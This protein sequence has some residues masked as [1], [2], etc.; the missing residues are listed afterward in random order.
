MSIVL[1]HKWSDETIIIESSN[2]DFYLQCFKHKILGKYDNLYLIEIQENEFRRDTSIYYSHIIRYRFLGYLLPNEDNI[3]SAYFLCTS[4]FQRIENLEECSMCETIFSEKEN[5]FFLN[6][7]Y[8]TDANTYKEYRKKYNLGIIEEFIR[9]QRTS[10]SNPL[11]EEIIMES[12][13][14]RRIQRVLDLT[15]DLENLEDY[16]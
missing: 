8:F 13:H 9:D 10:L 6:Y 3:L 7:S 1:E 2:L 15:D 14:P 11:K 12:M 5:P 4:C 16:I